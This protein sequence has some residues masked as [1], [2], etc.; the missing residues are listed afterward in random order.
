MDI[1][2]HEGTERYIRAVIALS[3]ETDK[4]LIIRAAFP[5]SVPNRF[6]CGIISLGLF[7]F[8]A[9]SPPMNTN[10]AAAADNATWLSVIDNAT[11]LSVSDNATW[12][13]VTASDNA[14]WL[15]VQADNATWLV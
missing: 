6:H 11:W 9:R 4:A 15:N 7:P 2:L 12:L 5:R 1:A 8:T 10:I 3:A 14:T 13:N